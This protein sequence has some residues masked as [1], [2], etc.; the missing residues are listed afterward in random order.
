MRWRQPDAPSRL[1]T[2]RT[3]AYLFEL[4]P[5]DSKS[6]LRDKLRDA[7]AQKNTFGFA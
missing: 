2:A 5:Y 7:L 3:C 1:P 6:T 4:P